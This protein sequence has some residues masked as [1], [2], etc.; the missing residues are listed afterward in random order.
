MTYIWQKSFFS[1]VLLMISG[2]FSIFCIN[3]MIFFWWNIYFAFYWIVSF[4]F[5]VWCIYKFSWILYVFESNWIKIYYK[6]ILRQEKLFYLDHI[7]IDN[8]QKTNIFFHQIWK[9]KKWSDLFFV[10]SDQ[11]VF[12]IITKTWENIYIS[13]RIWFD[14]KIFEKFG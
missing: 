12:L 8:I 6:N 4:C 13:P 3:Y 5:F 14:E 7:N 10:S 1:K 11:N 2:L 9:Y